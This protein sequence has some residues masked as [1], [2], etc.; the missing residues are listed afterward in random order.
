MHKKP[1]GFFSFALG[2]LAGS[3][4]M[5]FM[6]RSTGKKLRKEMISGW[7]K[8]GNIVET[9][10]KIYFRELMHAIKEVGPAMN[11]V[12]E[13]PQMKAEIAEGKKKLKKVSED[14]KEA[15]EKGEEIVKKQVQQTKHQAAKTL[16][17]V[18]GL[19]KNNVNEI[20]TKEIS[21]TEDLA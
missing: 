3:A 13:S 11:E 6:A 2:L 14:V 8:G 21:D 17:K 10:W 12:L 7:E 18:S 4:F 9:K 20:D 15:A 5:T 16:R 19:K 1:K